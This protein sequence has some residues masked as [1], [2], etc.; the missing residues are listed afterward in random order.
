MVVLVTGA[1]SQLA[2]C[3]KDLYDK[4]YECLQDNWIFL[5]HRQLDITDEMSVKNA[6][7]HLGPDIIVN[8]A[9]YTDVEKAEEEFMQAHKTNCIGVENLASEC[10][11]RNIVLIHISTDY[12]YGQNCGLKPIG[13]DSLLNP[14]SKYAITKFLGELV[15]KK[16]QG[17]IVIRTSWLYSKHGKNFVKTM[18]GKMLDNE[19][20]Q[21]V[22]DQVGRPTN[23]NDL[24]EFIMFSI[25]ANRN[26]SKNSEPTIYNFQDNG[27]ECTWY[28]FAK[29]I[30]EYIGSTSKVIPISSSVFESKATRPSYSTM[31]ITKASKYMHILA[32]D[33]SLKLFIKEYIKQINK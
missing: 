23:A 22:D 27:E 30:K 13:E 5:S 18:V 19:D 6:L 2:L 1:N 20:V 21:V 16:T 33:V 31:D 32:W 4:S 14:L 24:A 17:S 25:V 26:F 15:C 11:A 8:C 12:V 29:K 28:E 9:A 3:L 7:D 10:Q